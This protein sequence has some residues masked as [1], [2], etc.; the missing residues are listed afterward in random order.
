MAI[1]C[2]IQRGGRQISGAV[3]HTDRTANLIDVQTD[4]VT[5]WFPARLVTPRLQGAGLVPGDEAQAMGVLTGRPSDWA[6][7][8]E[9]ALDKFIEGKKGKE[10]AT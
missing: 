3:L 8:D 2:F 7:I 1:R 4:V 9:E 10:V 5:D 6:E